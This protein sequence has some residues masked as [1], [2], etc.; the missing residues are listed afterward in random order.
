MTLS[1][2]IL[3][4]Q[5]FLGTTPS[6]TEISAAVSQYQQSGG[7]IQMTGAGSGSNG[8]IVTTDQT[9]VY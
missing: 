9:V 6:Q 1:A 5:L 7:T 8:I 4:L 2:L 3:A